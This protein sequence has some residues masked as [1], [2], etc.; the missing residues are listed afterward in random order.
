MPVG[1][2]RCGSHGDFRS[3]RRGLDI[4]AVVAGVRGAASFF[5]DVRACIHHVYS[6]RSI[7]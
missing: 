3:A 6:Y 7:G 2:V 4:H 5:V 1:F